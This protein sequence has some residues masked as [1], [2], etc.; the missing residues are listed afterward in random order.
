MADIVVVGAGHNG[1]V[2]ALELAS[3]GYDTVVV[4]G[5]D[6]VGGAVASGEVTVPGFVHD[7]YAT[8]LNLFLASS[9]YRR[10]AADLER[11]GL[12]FRTTDKPF[13]SV[14]A[15]GRAIRIYQ[16]SERTL[17]LLRAFSAADA[18]GWERLGGEFARFAPLL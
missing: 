9:V 7:L 6:R 4:E 11:H 16:D 1:L 5:N 3:R 10:R 12:R 15:G 14:F 13:S 17:R 18:A 2:A 8:N